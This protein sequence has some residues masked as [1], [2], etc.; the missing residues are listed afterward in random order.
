MLRTVVIDDEPNARQVVKNVV[1]LYCDSAVVVGEAENVQEGVKIINKLNPDLVL[2]DIRMPDGT[3][4]DLLK[5]VKNLNFH[6]IFI[7]AFEEYAIQA[8]K[9]SALDYIVKPINTNELISAIEKANLTSV[10]EK[11]QISKI[12]TFSYNEKNSTGNNRLVLNTQESIYVVEVSE[13]ISCKADKNYTEV[14]VLNK[15]KLVISK[16]LK[17]FEEMLKG[18][19]FFRTHQSYLVNLDYINHYEKG[20]GGTIIMQDN[21]RVPVSSRK[22]DVF[23][24]LMAK[25]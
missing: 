6:F 7:T 19:S 8:I 25:M 14:N 5:K 17:D 22:K 20:L 13:I 9:L 12:D 10:K 18:G 24:Q 21:S 4:F 15:N 16:T 1:E 11:D 23:L 2:L 3:G